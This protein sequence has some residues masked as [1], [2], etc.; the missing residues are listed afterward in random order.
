VSADFIDDGTNT[1]SNSFGF[2]GHVSTE[3]PLSGKLS[4]FTLNPEL[5]F[6]LISFKGRAEKSDTASVR[7]ATERQAWISL[8]VSL[9]YSVH[10]SELGTTNYYV[11][12]GL[13]ADYLLNPAK[14]IVAN[15]EFYS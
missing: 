11:S 4:K 6:H 9:Q 15:I 7:P 2:A 8:P 1:I 3:I 12:A 14:Q 13:S 10:E 5:S